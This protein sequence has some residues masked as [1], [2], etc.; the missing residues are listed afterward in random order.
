MILLWQVSYSHIKTYLAVLNSGKS[1]EA[2]FSDGNQEKNADEVMNEAPKSNEKRVSVEP[3][4]NGEKASGPLIENQEERIQSVHDGDALS[5]KRIKVTEAL[6]A[7]ESSV[8]DW[9][10]NFDDG[11][12]EK[13]SYNLS[14]CFYVFVLFFNFSMD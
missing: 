13:I 6:E 14:F 1:M 10:K 7:T 2:I 5:N 8:L 4:N 3:E 12:S 11:V 9:I